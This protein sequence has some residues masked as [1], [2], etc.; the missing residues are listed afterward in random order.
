[1]KYWIFTLYFLM[2]ALLA[3]VHADDGLY[4]YLECSP[5]QDCIQLAY[6]NGKTESVQA[7]PVQVLARADIQSASIQQGE[8]IPLSLK[9]K[10]RKEAS[11]AF[12]KITGENIGK[13]LLVVF[14]NKILNTPTINAPIADPVII[15]GS[16]Y[17]E[18][19]PFWKR[20][21]WLQDLIKD[22]N[23]ARGRSIMIYGIVALVVLLAAF[24]FVLLP[25][26]RRTRPS[27]PE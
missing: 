13:K 26:M 23:R 11:A 17:D 9:I 24:A 4:F 7:A 6:G 22:S 20:A 1:M 8:G 12:E 3:S 2:H 25:R 21:S 14:D 15:I 27:H 19:G 10:L 18:Q 16:G 5:G